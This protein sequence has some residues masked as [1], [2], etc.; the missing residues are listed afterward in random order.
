MSAL[1]IRK[2]IVPLHYQKATSLSCLSRPILEPKQTA[3]NTTWVI[4][5]QK[6]PSGLLKKKC[7]PPKIQVLT[8]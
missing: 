4:V 8:S 6:V 1:Q 2:Q 3:P 7:N 5:L